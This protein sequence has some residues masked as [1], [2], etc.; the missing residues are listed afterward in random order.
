MAQINH[1]R[2][3][4]FELDAINKTIEVLEAYKAGKRVEYL[5]DIN[6][7]VKYHTTPLINP[8]ETE[9]YRIVE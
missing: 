5:T 8:L 2:I 9:R 6:G 1:N 4:D 7:W 3:N